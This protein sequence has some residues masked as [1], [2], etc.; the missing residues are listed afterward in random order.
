L[1][2]SISF[3][4]L[5]VSV[6][7]SHTHM[8]SVSFCISLSLSHSLCI[9]LSLSLCFSVS[10]SSQVV[11]SARIT[12]CQGNPTPFP[13][14]GGSNKSGKLKDSQKHGPGVY[15]MVVGWRHMCVS[16]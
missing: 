14:S 3:L 12:C 9:S 10:L 8:L 15:I 4:T 16:I 6:C 7:P 11:Q 2:S 1:L 5:L 13:S